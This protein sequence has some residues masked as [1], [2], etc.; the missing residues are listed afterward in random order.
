MTSNISELLLIASFIKG[1]GPR[2]LKDLI[3]MLNT[4]T[5]PSQQDLYNA[6]EKLAQNR[7]SIDLTIQSFENAVANSKEQIEK[8]NALCIDIICSM[9]DC[10]PELLKNSSYDPCILYVKGNIKNLSKRAIA[11]IG[12]RNPTEIGDKFAYRISN[13]LAS[14][15]IVVVSGLALG[16]D[17]RAHMGALDAPNGQTIAVLAHGL[18]SISPS[19]NKQLADWI[20][21]KGG[22][23]I[24]TYPI[25]TK[26]SAYTFPAR[27]KI[28][29]GLS[30]KVVL[31][32]S[33]ING[34]SL[35]ASE[36]CL[37][38]NR[39]L[40]VVRP[41]WQDLN[42]NVSCIGANLALIKAKEN[43]NT[44]SLSF[45]ESKSVLKSDFLQRI[46]IL[47][48]KDEYD[49]IFDTAPISS[50]FNKLKENTHGYDVYKNVCLNGA[51]IDYLFL[52][53]KKSSFFFNICTS[54]ADL[55]RKLKE[56][57]ACKAHLYLASTKAKCVTLYLAVTNDIYFN[58]DL[59]K[60]AQDN[61]VHLF[62]ISQKESNEGQICAIV[63]NQE[64][65]E[66]KAQADAVYSKIKKLLLFSPT[67]QDF[68]LDLSKEQQNIIKN[69]KTKRVRITGCAGS[70]KS[71]VVA[72]RAA[73]LLYQ[74]KS[75][76]VTS[77]NIT[78]MNYLRAL[79][80]KALCNPE[81]LG[82][83][84]NEIAPEKVDMQ[85]LAVIHF[86]GFLS[87]VRATFCKESDNVN[88]LTKEETQRNIKDVLDRTPQELIVQKQYDAIII[89]EG[90]DFKHLWLEILNTFLKEDGYLMLLADASQDIY[91]HSK[92]L[93]KTDGLHFK[94][95]WT[96]LSRSY[97]MPNGLIDICSD[98]GAKFIPKDNDT[99]EF[100]A[101]PISE[102]G[103]QQEFFGNL[104]IKWYQRDIP[105]I[106]TKDSLRLHE[107]MIL[108]K[109][110]SVID[111]FVNK[112]Q[113]PLDDICVLCNSRKFG[114]KIVESLEAN[115]IPTESIFSENSDTCRQEKLNMG[116][117][118][119]C[120]KC[121]TTHSFKGWE[122]YNVILV[123]IHKNTDPE[124]RKSLTPQDEDR[125]TNDKNCLL[126]V[127]LT[128][129]N[130]NASG[131][132]N[133]IVINDFPE[134]ADFFRNL[135]SNGE[136]GQY[137]DLD[138]EKQQ[139]T[140]KVIYYEE[141]D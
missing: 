66:D 118:P 138:Y 132:N 119:G 77:F 26:P 83:D 121:S 4:G 110:Q 67:Q 117:Q 22:C 31:I 29:A 50:K 127:G 9:D 84:E 130:K 20:V 112:K 141:I 74:G 79:I 27:D 135:F 93:I 63:L 80:E 78:M 33:G 106:R 7:K 30:E 91:S 40:V 11:V 76:L 71:L 55:Y 100:R 58:A 17:T 10:Y 25:G 99:D 89:D 45:F 92:E 38:D 59:N 62:T 124:D 48:K 87:I 37:E 41:Y 82:L 73:R 34:G 126:Y 23:L 116:S 90:Q 81:L 28:Q 129:V 49:R 36:A 32:Q 68:F 139:C 8:A 94:G 18:D 101:Y 137:I 96:K 98:F 75:V 64:L 134:Y 43:N 69:D 125:I 2:A 131:E 88:Y 60:E 120:L 122:S 57:I 114:R 5:A 3:Q 102:G 46:E 85:K 47:S 54:E 13:Y 19:Q 104:N 1:I 70:G 72:L 16:C 86:H 123:N 44:D 61:H 109:I 51:N 97:R 107:K 21:Q 24:S 103:I 140:A 14:N 15:N 56:L 111:E 105:L 95:R 128:R 133:L 65:S 113:I 6:I 39:N 108:L 42:N 52:S 35:I 115:N 12:T 136:E 53:A